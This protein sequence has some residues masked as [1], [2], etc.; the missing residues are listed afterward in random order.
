MLKNQN[1]FYI[2]DAFSEELFGGNPA[3]IVILPSDSDFPDDI[4]MLRVAAEL[5]YSE[6]AFVRQLGESRFHTRY[7]TPAAEVELC[8]HATVGAFHVL[9]EIGLVNPG[10][11]CIN[12][13]AAGELRVE[14]GD[15]MILMDMASPELMGEFESSEVDELCSI[16][17]CEPRAA[18]NLQE[19]NFEN[20]ADACAGNLRRSA[21][22]LAPR[23]VSTGLPDI[24]F[25]VTDKAALA[26]LSPDYLALAA[27][28][29]RFGAVGVHAFSYSDNEDVFLARNFAPLYGIDEEAATGT[30]NA[31]L[32]YYLYKNGAAISDRVY[33]VIQG[34]EMHRPSKVHVKIEIPNKKAPDDLVIK[35]GGGAVTLA[36][37]IINI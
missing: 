28:S 11:V 13:T 33:T 15:K 6:T 29:E 16:M 24:I 27:F 35:V 23:K 34:A 26:S 12:R 18:V 30:A 20:F 1:N 31:A 14:I 9:R 37:G 21:A 2:V 32:L 3:G 4:R 5:R 8:G 25:G 10:E 36:S 17:G 7:F 22:E 19:K